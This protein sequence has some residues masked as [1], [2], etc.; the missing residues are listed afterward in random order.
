MK[1]YH[2]FVVSS[3]GLVYSQLG[4]SVVD[5]AKEYAGSGRGFTVTRWEQEADVN[6]T[7]DVYRH[8]VKEARSRDTSVC[9]FPI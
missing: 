3:P 6:E 5:A 7:G 4:Q 9:C 2:I 1:W 8:V